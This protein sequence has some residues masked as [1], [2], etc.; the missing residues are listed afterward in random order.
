R[1]RRGAPG[2]PPAT[3]TK[4]R[5]PLPHRT[6]GERALLTGSLGAP[7]VR[8]E[9]VGCCLH[10]QAVLPRGRPF[11]R[12]GTTVG[13]VGAD[14]L[15]LCPGGKIRVPKGGH[16]SISHASSSRPSSVTVASSSKSSSHSVPVE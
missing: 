1:A 12:V 2:Q 14:P 11:R 16:A 6:S 8:P 10:G 15:P 9:V 3:P 7:V 4:G 13:E 5:R